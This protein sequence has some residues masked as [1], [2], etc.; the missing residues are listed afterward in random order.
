MSNT[1]IA[2]LLTT[3]IALVGNIKSLAQP[4]I[5]GEL[6]QWHT[7]TLTFDGPQAD[8]QDENNPF[9]NYRLSVRF[10]HGNK[11]YLVPG[12]FAA[13]GNAANTSATSGNK[14][15][16]HFSPDATGVWTYEVAFRKGENVAVEDAAEA[17]ESAGFMDGLKGYFSVKPTNKK[18]PD[19][20]SKGRLEYTSGHYLRFAGTG[21]YFLKAGADAPE[22]FLAYADFDGDFK[23]DGHG[24]EF[25]KDWKAHLKDWTRKDPSW[26][27]GK[28][29]GIIGALNYLS[30]KGMNVFSFLTMNIAGDDKNV[31]P[32]VSYDDYTRIDVSK[33]DQWEIVFN[34]AQNL[35]LFLHFKTQE[36]ENQGLLDDGELGIHRKLYY[37]ELIARFSHH[38]ALNWNLGEENGYWM[39]EHP[40]PPQ[41]TEQRQAMAQYFHDHDPYHH[42]IVI[43]NGQTFDDLLGDSEL[44]GA[45]VQTFQQDFQDVHPAVLKWR[46]ESSQAG[47]P[48][49]V[50]VD[51]SGG[52]QHGVL[53]DAE[54]KRHDMARMNGLWGA[55]MAGAAGV[56]WYFGYEHPHS[57]LTCQDWRSRDAFWDQCWYAI[58]FFKGNNIPFWEMQ[59]QDDLTTNET[60]FVF[61]KPNEVYVIYQKLG[62]KEPT[63]LPGLQGAYTLQWYNPRTGKFAGKT[64]KLN[65][66]GSLEIGLPPTEVEQDWVVLVRKR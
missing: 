26:Q 30:S 13:D 58:A 52:V 47:K 64:Q 34:H 44:T 32:Y 66:T 45:S 9:L 46:E 59:P 28:G 19:F 33:L 55:Y 18:T 56:E 50:T 8:E 48:W 65:L 54:D 22:N 31:F 7:I 61:Y 40:T 63:L 2:F 23:T 38:L 57:D 21:D 35:G 36:A 24:D 29:K 41:T 16:V 49:V 27:T 62:K 39:R 37:R 60:D 51:E 53:P 6:R 10:N 43:H 5:S 17:G 25:V 14:W 1:T 11:S 20:R 42:L 4:Q 15:R 3:A 12:Y